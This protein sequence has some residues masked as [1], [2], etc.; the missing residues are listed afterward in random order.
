MCLDNG[1]MRATM[2]PLAPTAAFVHFQES[3]E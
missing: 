1:G 3:S 2:A